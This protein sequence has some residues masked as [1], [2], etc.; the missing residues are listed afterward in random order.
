MLFTSGTRLAKSR[1]IIPSTMGVTMN[2]VFWRYFWATLVA[3]VLAAASAA[4]GVY[5]TEILADPSSDWDGDGEV[6]TRGDEWIEVINTGPEV[7]DLAA[8][9]MRDALGEDPQLQLSGVLSPG[10]IKVFYGSDAEAWQT[11]TGLSVSGLSLNNAGDQLELYLGDPTGSGATLVDIV[12]YPDHTGDDDRS[13]ARVL[14]DGS[15]VLFDGLN[16]YGGSLEPT[17]TGCLPSPNVFNDCVNLVPTEEVG[18]G[19]FKQRYR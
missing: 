6:S 14:P 9:Y 4:G 16:P 11:Q 19:E 15:W 2:D 8:Y 7:V 17:G 12:I 13:L 5:L 1:R 18:W 10:G 3:V